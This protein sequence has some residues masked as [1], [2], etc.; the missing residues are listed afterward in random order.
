MCVRALR[1]SSS[2]PSARPPSTGEMSP[3]KPSVHADDL[4]ASC[5]LCSR[6]QAVENPLCA[7]R[8][9]ESFAKKT[10]S[11]RRKFEICG[12]AKLPLS[13]HAACVTYLDPMRI[14]W[15]GFGLHWMQHTA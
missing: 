11:D 7:H 10:R 3:I 4:N 1:L 9:T 5:C 8:C 13:N 15:A 6:V 2:A 12:A 14:G